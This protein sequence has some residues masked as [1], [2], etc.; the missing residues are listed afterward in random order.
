MFDLCGDLA[1]VLA[2]QGFDDGLLVVQ[3]AR[4][5]GHRWL[6]QHLLREGVVSPLVH[7]DTL[8]VLLLGRRLHLHQLT[9]GRDGSS[10]GSHGGGRALIV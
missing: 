4:L 10:I 1:E 3:L 8:L 5:A 9:T 6:G 7:P 2:E